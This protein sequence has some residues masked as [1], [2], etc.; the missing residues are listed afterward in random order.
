MADGFGFFEYA[1]QHVTM[2]FSGNV[3]CFTF[4][5]IERMCMLENYRLSFAFHFK[6][7]IN[8]IFV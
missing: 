4:R 3:T 6:I 5:K 8:R 1:A 7:G 2:I